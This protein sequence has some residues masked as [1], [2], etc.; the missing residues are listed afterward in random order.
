M[1][2]TMEAAAP[3][4]QSPGLGT[5]ERVTNMFYAPS[6][7]FAD[8]Q[9]SSNWLYAWLIMFAFSLVFTISVGQKIGWSAVQDN[10]IKLGPASQREALEKLPADQRERQL[11]IS[12]VVTKV[13]GYGFPVL[14]LAGWAIVA[15]I[16][17]GTFSFG[18]GSEINYFKSL[19]IVVFASV[20]HI[21]LR[22]LMATAVVW[23]GPDPEG[24]FIQNPVGTNPGWYM[25]PFESSRFLYAVATE[26]DAFYLWALFLTGLGFSIVGKV[27]KGTAMAVVFGWAAAVMLI[28]GAVG[29]AFAGK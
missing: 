20:P 19:A 25:N 29:Q 27:K 28:G 1:T 13:L 12:L 26:L 9:R 16:L 23:G 2:E 5:I 8:L 22:G 24:F 6:R 17:W 7:T 15:L 10:N 21:I 14:R 4:S 11:K 3:Q 18:L